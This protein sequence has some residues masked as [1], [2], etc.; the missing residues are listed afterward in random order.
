MIKFYVTNTYTH[1]DLQAFSTKQLKKLEKIISYKVK[2]AFFSPAYKRHGWDGTMSLLKKT[3]IDRKHVGYRFPTGLFSYIHKL[4]PYSTVDYAEETHLIATSNKYNSFDDS[5]VIFFADVELPS[6]DYL[7]NLFEDY[8]LR[9]HQVYMVE[10]MIMKGRGVVEAATGAGKTLVSA[11][12]TKYLDVPTVITVPTLDILYQT[13]TKFAEYFKL[14][15]DEFGIIGDQKT[16]IRKITIASVPTLRER[17]KVNNRGRVIFHND[18]IA[19][20][21]KSRQL[22]IADEAHMVGDNTFFE[23]SLGFINAPYRFGLSA[24][25]FDRTDGNA[26]MLRGATGPRIAKVSPEVLMKTGYLAIPHIIIHKISGPRISGA[27]TYAEAYT[28]GIVNQ[29]VRNKKI[30]DLIEQHKDEKII[31][32]FERKKHGKLLSQMLWEMKI[33]HKL[34]TGDNFAEEREQARNELEHGDLNIILASMIFKLGVDLPAVKVLIRAD[35][36]QSTISTIQISGRALRIKD[37]DNK[38][39]IYDF[40]DGHQKFLKKHSRARLKDYKKLGSM[41]SI[42]QIDIESGQ[43]FLVV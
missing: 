28:Q 38:V 22:L 42:D 25:P 3:Y 30:L 5:K 36:K 21:F 43:Q 9:P 41:V 39:I 37:G 11:A 40:Y 34:L 15:I 33:N 14:D 32:I 27:I 18:K 23:T 1:F 12:V 13:R 2:G 20:F 6:K 8:K 10:K 26:L 24:T 16:E 29:P 17:M 7:I 35:G 4:F 31:V 19:E